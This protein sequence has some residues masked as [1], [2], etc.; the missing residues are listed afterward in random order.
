MANS[1]TAAAAFGLVAAAAA[2]ALW[3]RRGSGSPSS[4]RTTDSAAAAG[5][6]SA[7]S[8][9]RMV[10]MVTGGAGLVGMGIQAFVAN[11][12][13]PSSS[14][15]EKWV[16]LSSK[17][18][19]LRCVPGSCLACHCS[20]RFMWWACVR[21]SVACCTVCLSL[22]NVGACGVVLCE[23]CRHLDSL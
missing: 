20:P 6:E 11:N 21:S 1:V 2:A 16:F 5:G 4:R 19:D 18:G 8:P 10:I 14:V 7:G 3:H 22:V 15:G 13:P 17:D 9:E 23:P 12:P